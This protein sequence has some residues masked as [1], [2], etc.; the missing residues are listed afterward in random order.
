MNL[1][2]TSNKQFAVYLG[3]FNAYSSLINQ[4]YEPY[5]YSTDEAGYIGAVLIVVGLVGSAILSPILDRSHAFLIAIRIQVPLIGLGFIA[6]IF[7]P[8]SPPNLVGPMIVCA[9]LGAASFSLLP[10]GLEYCVEQTHPVSPEVTSTILWTGGQL[11][12][13]VF[14]IIM[15]AMRDKEPGG[16][17]GRPEGNMWAALVFEGVIAALVIPAAF[18]V[19]KRKV[20]RGRVE[21][22]QEAV[23]AAAARGAG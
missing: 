4:V 21:V 13:G 20:G 12:G 17:A 14:L 1:R 16:S 11:L 19:K 8:T 3:F 23:R 7:T 15:D 6:M 5:G 2:L 22:D 18:F 10:I 9:I